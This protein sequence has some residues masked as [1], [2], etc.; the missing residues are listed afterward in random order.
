MKQKINNRD[1]KSAI[2]QQAVAQFETVNNADIFH[3]LGG[4]L[5]ESHI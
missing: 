4:K 1:L 2:G 3:Q 5:A